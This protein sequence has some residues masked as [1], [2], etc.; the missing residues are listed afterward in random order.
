M[1]EFWMSLWSIIWFVSLAIFSVLTVMV[2]IFGGHDLHAL[3]SAL[4][5]R[6]GEAVAKEQAEQ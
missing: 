2:I 3:L 6:H 5:V 1:T 4:R